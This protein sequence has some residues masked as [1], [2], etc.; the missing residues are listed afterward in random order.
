MV[1]IDTS[2]STKKINITDVIYNIKNYYP[3]IKIIVL[4]DEEDNCYYPAYAIIKGQ[5]SSVDFKE[6]IKKANEDINNADYNASEIT[7]ELKQKTDDS[8]NFNNSDITEKLS[9][10]SNR[11]DNL[12]TFTPELKIKPPNIKKKKK[13][14]NNHIVLISCIAAGVLVLIVILCIILKSIN[15][16]YNAATIDEI[17]TQST[18][19]NEIPTEEETTEEALTFSFNDPTEIDDNIDII[20]DDIVSNSKSDST[21]S[22]QT[23][24]ESSN[25]SKSSSSSSKNNSSSSSSSSLGNNNSSKNSSDLIVSSDNISNSAI[26]SYDD[27]QYKNSQNNQ[28]SSIKLSY[29]KKTLYIGDDITL[30][31]TV[32]PSNASYSLSWSSSNS[33][34]SVNQ[35]G[36]V[37]ANSIGTATITCQAGDKYATCEIIVVSKPTVDTNSNNPIS[38]S[39]TSESIV[40]GQNITLYL[41]NSKNAN[42]TINNPSILQTVS[43]GSNKIVVKGIKTGTTTII[44]TDISSGQTYRCKITVN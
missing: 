38:L 37:T 13:S 33:V 41:Y 23:K 7:E 5:V 11:V 6:L 40:L 4:A 21:T 18:L 39:S 2:V 8:F 34:A 19:I 28:V 36:K 3:Y 42:W 43:G 32:S 20:S 16:V 15:S 9:N 25:T 10:Q 12:S 26:I 30:T 14:S 24:A 1:I 17:A 22:S 35:S 44:A 27:N 29:T 31:A